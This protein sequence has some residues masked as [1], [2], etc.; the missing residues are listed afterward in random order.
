[1]DSNHAHVTLKPIENPVGNT[2][3]S[4]AGSSFLVQDH[5]HCTLSQH[6][7]T[8]D[9]YVWK[10]ITKHLIIITLVLYV[11]EYVYIYCIVHSSFIAT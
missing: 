8:K 3:E 9:L 5:W 11:D 1:M 4:C 2:A 6:F 10:N 7:Q